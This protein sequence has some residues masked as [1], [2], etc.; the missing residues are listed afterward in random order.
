MEFNGDALMIDTDMSMEEIIK[1]EEFIRPR[2]D[3]IETIEVEEGCALKS[4]AL[5]SIL[6][7]L[8][9]TRPKLQIPF[10]EKGLSI[11]PAYGTIHWIY[12]D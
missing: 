3:F 6:V 5:L 9:K 10:L 1:F 11:A 8:K 7:S 2:I 12:H 4:S